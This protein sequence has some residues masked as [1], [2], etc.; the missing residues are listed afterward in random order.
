MKTCNVCG[1][2][3]PLEHFQRYWNNQRNRYCHQPQCKECRKAQR[4]ADTATKA[5]DAAKRRHKYA[6]DPAYRE[7]QREI[8]LK[9]RYGVTP[10]K[11]EELSAAQDGK[12]A[13]CQIPLAEARGKGAVVDH[14][15][16]CCPG[17]KTCGECIRG[18]LCAH[19]N[20]ALGMFEDDVARLLA[21]VDYLAGLT[22]GGQA[23]LQASVSRRKG[24][25]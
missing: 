2:T 6:T 24:I 25:N 20:T 21:A 19:C 14:D 5:K 8:G 12:C 15:H 3:L 4:R 23:N 22:G 18:V 11:F 1:E 13:I 9:Y 16:N 7:R 17:S 10:E